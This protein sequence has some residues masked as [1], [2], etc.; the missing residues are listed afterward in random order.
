[1]APVTLG[2][3]ASLIPPDCVVHPTRNTIM[4]SFSAR[5]LRVMRAAQVPKNAARLALGLAAAGA[6]VP[7][8]TSESAQEAAPVSS[9]A[10][11]QWLTQA[12]AKSREVTTALALPQRA[13]AGDYE[14]EGVIGEGGY[15]RVHFGRHRKSRAPVAIKR[16]AKSRTT[17]EQFLQ[18]VAILERVGGAHGVLALR[19][20]FETRDAFVL[21]TELV[22][23][24]ELYDHLV[25]H[26][27]F[28]ERDARALAR[29]LAQ[30]L[31]YLHAQA[32]VHADLKPENILLTAGQDGGLRL[33]DFGQSFRVDVDSETEAASS[34]SSNTSHS[35][36]SGGNAVT[37]GSYTLAY[38]SPE[39]LG[40]EGDDKTSVGRAVDVW[41]LGVVLFI[42]LCGHHP[43]DPSDDATDEQLQ[44]R[45]RS[46]R[47]DRDCAGWKRLSPAVRELIDQMLALDPAQRPTAEQVLAHPWIQQQQQ[48][49]VAA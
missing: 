17:R 8:S 14:V 22:R 44:A 48:E 12:P 35:S 15:A 21:V 38:A 28:S 46:G 24:G 33:I 47:V 34:S 7:L 6:L 43:F 23:G 11:W 26:G 32:V 40:A 25:E 30:S 27:V 18:E 41:A 31:A 49:E 36:S 29:E 42:V 19:E 20:A 10:R 4:A 13:L 37:R 9:G 5:V 3:A 1:M 45:I 16:V 39:L 2:S